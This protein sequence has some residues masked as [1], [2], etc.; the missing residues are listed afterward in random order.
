MSI[1][2]QRVATDSYGY[3]ALATTE[4]RLPTRRRRL[5]FLIAFSLLGGSMAY[6][7]PQ[8][9]LSGIRALGLLLLALVAGL[10]T[11]WSS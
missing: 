3:A 2:D 8:T 5:I 1:P 9:A 7:L 10:S 4:V 11:L 6:M